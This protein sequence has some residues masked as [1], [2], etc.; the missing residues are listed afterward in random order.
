L[1]EQVNE[2]AEWMTIRND[3]H[4]VFHLYY[5]PDEI[6]GVY[7]IELNKTFLDQEEG[8]GGL[9][10]WW[11]QD[12]SSPDLEEPY[13]FY[14]ADRFAKQAVTVAK[15]ALKEVARRDMELASWAWYFSQPYRTE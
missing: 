14:V 6:H 5:R 2:S 1:A 9:L 15:S 10:S 8:V 13:R 4:Q 11:L 12:T 7:K 3:P